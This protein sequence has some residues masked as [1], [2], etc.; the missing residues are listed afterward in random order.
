VFPTPAIARRLVRQAWDEWPVDAVF[1]MLYHRFYR[2]EL[3]WIG[4]GVREGVAAVRG[5]VPLVAGL[6]LPDLPPADLGRAVR[7]VR[8]NGASGAACFEMRGLTDAHLAAL[9]SALS[10]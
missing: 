1:P 3:P 2:E 5:R 8:K 7:L 10:G 6:Y 9:R 4:R